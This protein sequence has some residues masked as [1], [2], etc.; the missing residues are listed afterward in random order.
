MAI[1]G[2]WYK[3][4]AAHKL[5]HHKGKCKN[6][7]GHSYQICVSLEGIIQSPGEASD[8]GMVLD[9][10]EIDQIVDPLVVHSLD[11]KY[12][13][14]SLGGDFPTTAEN[15]ACWIFNTVQKD[16]NRKFGARVVIKSVVVHETS[17]T[18]AEVFME[19]WVKWLS[20]FPS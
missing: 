14:E 12:L 11:H 9:Y 16:I 20:D 6:L 5:D 13:N 3:F 10:D 7:H 4:E 18:Y 2:K 1:I 17:S 8:A 19:D 15:I